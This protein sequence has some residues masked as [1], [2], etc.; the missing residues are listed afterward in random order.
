MENNVSCHAAALLMPPGA[1]V[2]TLLC[3][4]LL[5]CATANQPARYDGLASS[6][7]LGIGGQSPNIKLSYSAPD[8]EWDK[9]ADFVLDPVSIYSGPDS[10]LD[11]TSAADKTELVRYMQAQFEEVLKSRYRQVSDAGPGTLR[12]HLTL[13]GVETNT[14]LLSTLANVLPVGLVVNGVMSANGAQASFSGSIS[15]AVE[16]YEGKSD[17]LLRAYVTKQYPMAI[18]ISSS[19]GA[20]DAAKAGI[21]SGAVEMLKQIH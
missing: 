19:L 8:N 5:G 12:I 10:L 3:A 4:S 7:K 17:R 21:R 13:I 1:L 2:V 16:V 14:P 20:L 6:P 15:Y 11:D 9:Y 18:D